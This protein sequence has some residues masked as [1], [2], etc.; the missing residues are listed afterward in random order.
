[1]Y[2]AMQAEHPGEN[3][4]AWQRFLPTGPVAIL[5]LDNNVSSLVW[6]TTPEYVPPHQQAADVRIYF[7]AQSNVAPP[8]SNLLQQ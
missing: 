3:T 6:S 2:V 4:I 7:A 5:P 1:V 8:L